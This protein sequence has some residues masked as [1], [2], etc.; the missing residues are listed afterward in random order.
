[1]EGKTRCS[2][3]MTENQYRTFIKEC[4]RSKSLRWKPRQEAMKDAARGKQINRLSG[5]MA[6]HYECAG[7][8]SLFPSKLVAMDHIHRVVP[9]VGFTSWDDIAERMYCE[10]GGFQALCAEC[11]GLKTSAEKIIA[12][13][14]KNGDLDLTGMTDEEIYELVKEEIQHLRKEMN[15]A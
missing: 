10:K 13:L 8:S 3:T 11:H 14:H 7:C 1:M 4:L 5:R 9:L 12:R 6:E 2:G 15:D